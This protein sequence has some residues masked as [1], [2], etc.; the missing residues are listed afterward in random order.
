LF[1]SR[2]GCSLPGFLCQIGA[3]GLVGDVDRGQAD[4][5]NRNAVAGFYL[6]K[7]LRAGNGHLPALAAGLH[8]D[9]SPN[10]FNDSS[11]HKSRHGLHGFAGL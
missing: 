5:T 1:Q 2:E 8:G 9:Y 3:E 10:F 7:N 4:A 6:G 11:K